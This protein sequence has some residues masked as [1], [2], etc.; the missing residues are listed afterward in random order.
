MVREA[1]V[2]LVALSTPTKQKEKRKRQAFMY[3]K[4]KKSTRIQTSRLGGTVEGHLKEGKIL[5]HT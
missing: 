4:A 2:V 5:W 3:F 1:A